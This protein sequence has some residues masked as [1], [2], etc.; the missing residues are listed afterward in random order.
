VL[1]VFARPL[2]DMFIGFA[3]FTDGCLKHDVK[4]EDVPPTELKT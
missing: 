2:A 4:I 1:K 3:K